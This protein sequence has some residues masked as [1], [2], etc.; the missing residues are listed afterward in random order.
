MWFVGPGNKGLENRNVY[1]HCIFF[2]DFIANR[3]GQAPP[4]TGLVLPFLWTVVALLLIAVLGASRLGV[5]VVV[6]ILFGS[7]VSKQEET[8]GEEGRG[9]STDLSV[10]QSM[11]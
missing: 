2:G 6:P 10:A 4:P 1:C 3:A 7:A 11:R 5:E 9:H 8:W